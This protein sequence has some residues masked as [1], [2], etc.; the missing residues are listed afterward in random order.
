M[1]QTIGET[2]QAMA[3][4]FMDQLQK[5]LDKYSREDEYYLLVHGKALKN[6]NVEG[7]VTFKQVFLK[8]NVCPPA[9]LASIRIHVN[10]KKGCYKMEVFPHD[11]PIDQSVYGTDSEIVPEVYESAFKVKNSILYQGKNGK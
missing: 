1:V 9:Y 4:G 5:I 7:K 10:N 2:R 8:L 11:V 6:E 3:E